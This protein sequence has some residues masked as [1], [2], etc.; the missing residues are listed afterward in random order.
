MNFN[1]LVTDLFKQYKVRIWM[2]AVNPASVVNPA[3]AMQTPP[4]SAIGPGAILNQAAGH[5]PLPVGP[6]FG[7]NNRRSNEQYGECH[8]KAQHSKVRA[9]T[10][11]DAT[12]TTLPKVCTRARARVK[13]TVRVRATTMMATT[14][15]PTS[16]QPTQP[17]AAITWLLGPTLSSSFRS[18]PTIVTAATL[19]ATPTSRQPVAP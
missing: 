10:E 5:A 13:V 18:T 3:G 12:A 9:N 7:G 14:P 1:E 17:R 19:A 15:S 8:S 11:K 2:S 16:F 6:G 4:P